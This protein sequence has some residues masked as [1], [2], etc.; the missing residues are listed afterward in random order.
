MQTPWKESTTLSSALRILCWHL[1]CCWHGMCKVCLTSKEMQNE[2][3]EEVRG[4]WTE[5]QLP[6]PLRPAASW[7]QVTE[8]GSCGAA[9][10]QKI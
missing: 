4:P 7:G 9:V 6:Q 10:I 5:I 1:A 8:P 2:K 3:N